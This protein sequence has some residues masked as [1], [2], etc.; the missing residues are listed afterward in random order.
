MNCILGT[1]ND[2]NGSDWSPALRTK[3]NGRFRPKIVLKSAWQSQQQQQQQDTSE[4]SA[5]GSTKKLVREEGQSTPTDNPRASGNRCEVLC[6]LLRK[7]SLDL[8]D[9]RIEGIAQ[10]VTLKGGER[11]GQIQ[12][13]VDKFRTGYRTTSII[14]DLGKTRKSIKFSEESSRTIHELGNIDLHK[15]GQMSRTTQC[16]SCLKHLLE[17]LIF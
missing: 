5:S 6:H 1:F 12:K 3:A 7:K 4:S 2:C 10:D 14:E 16:Q 15:L 13:V 9:L 8:V 11:M 17:R